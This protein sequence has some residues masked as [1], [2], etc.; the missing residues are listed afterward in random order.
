M[1]VYDRTDV[2]DFVQPLAAI[3]ADLVSSGIKS[4]VPA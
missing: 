3:A 1:D 4:E 2:Q